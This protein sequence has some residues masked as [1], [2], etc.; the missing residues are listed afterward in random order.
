MLIPHSSPSQ[1]RSP[2]Q[3]REKHDAPG[4]E[5]HREFYLS[6]LVGQVSEKF[7]CFPMV[8]VHDSVTCYAHLYW[9]GGMALLEEQERYGECLNCEV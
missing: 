8:C 4:S 5:N 3:D 7:R 9:R 6:A 1:P 2:T